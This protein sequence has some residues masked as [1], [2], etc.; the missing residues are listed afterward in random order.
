MF[1]RNPSEF[2]RRYVT[3][4]KTWIHYYTPETKE[5]SKQW[6]SPGQRAPKKAKTV[7]SAGKVMATIFWDSRDIIFIDY[8]EKGKT[9]TGQYYASLLDRFHA[10][11]MEKR[12][13]LA[14][15]KILFHHD[16]AP[17]HTAAIAMAKIVKLQYE[18]LPHP[19][20]S[21]DLAPCD[22]F[23]FPNMKK[24]LG[25]KRFAS[26]EEIIAET[27][28]YFAAFENSYFLEGLKKLENRWAK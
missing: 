17:A 16:N 28:A 25:G 4:D 7:P 20:Y 1:K 19:P 27:N 3:V 23:L 12:P 22:F 15:K 8:L 10:E 9:I 11:L 14:K 18:L 26:N 13:H 21:P 5:Q 6:I 24:W 2:L